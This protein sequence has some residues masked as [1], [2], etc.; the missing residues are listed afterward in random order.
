MTVATCWFCRRLWEIQPGCRQASSVYTPWQA[1]DEQQHIYAAPL[2]CGWNCCLWSWIS[3]KN[4][5]WS[6]FQTLTLS[7]A[8]DA[9]LLAPTVKLL[10]PWKTGRQKMRKTIHR[11]PIIENISTYWVNRRHGIVDE[12]V[13]FFFRCHSVPKTNITVLL[14]PTV[15][16]STVPVQTNTFE[17]VRKIG[18][19]VLI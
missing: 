9:N 17:F 11:V 3:C 16:S 6:A 10:Q 13:L 8:M 4:I 18:M 1:D 7:L 2:S 15:A 5:N 12:V 19:Y 14:I